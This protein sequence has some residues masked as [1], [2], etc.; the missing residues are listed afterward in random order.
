MNSICSSRS[1]LR[2]CTSQADYAHFWLAPSD[3]SA[4][5]AAQ[6]LRDAW[7][8]T[9]ACAGVAPPAKILVVD[10]PRKARELLRRECS[11]IHSDANRFLADKV[12]STCL[13]RAEKKLNPSV[14]ESMDLYRYFE[15]AV[16]QRGPHPLGIPRALW[17][18]AE[19]RTFER[20]LMDSGFPSRVDMEI[21]ESIDEAYLEH[22]IPRDFRDPIRVLALG[23]RSHLQGTDPE[24]LSGPL[25]LMRHAAFVAATEGV[26][27]LVH[28]PVECHFDREGHLHNPS[29]PA[30]RFADDEGSECAHFLHGAKVPKA[31]FSTPQDWLPQFLLSISNSDLRNALVAQIGLNTYL[32]TANARAMRI[33]Q[34]GGLYDLSHLS[35]L[36]RMGDRWSH[37][38]F[39]NPPSLLFFTPKEWQGCGTSLIQ[40]PENISSARDAAAWAFDLRG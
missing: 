33:D 40:V 25:T 19:P 22:W 8:Q 1:L 13:L 6:R 5:R 9:C 11:E 20:S 17:S 30:F 18:M 15:H 4:E 31:L 12:V 36:Q 26:A 14:Q 37:E 34:Y 16:R 10:S 32:E 23:Y 39:W 29:G 24:L 28:R 2:R 3:V 21:E 38:A 7:T 27:I 35:F